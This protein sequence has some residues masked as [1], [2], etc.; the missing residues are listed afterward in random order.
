[1]GNL[2]RLD[3]DNLDRFGVYSRLF[4]EERSYTNVEEIQRAGSIARLL[5]NY[6]V[7]ADDRVVVMM[8]NSPD[9][10][11]IF[12]AIWTI[13][14]T[15]VPVIPQWTA[16]E[17][18]EVFRNSEATIALSVP[19]LAGRVQEAG[20]LAGSLEHLLVFGD[21][22]LRRLR[23]RSIGPSAIWRSFYIRRE[24]RVRQKE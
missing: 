19:A 17:V 20:G 2:A 11:A 13:G 18:A 23:L 8:P 15:I 1:V 24:R 22:K 10:S 14:A 12:P 9:L 5:K 16:G 7:K 4:Y 6:G 21:A 3:L